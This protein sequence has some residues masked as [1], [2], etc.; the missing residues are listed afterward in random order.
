MSDYIFPDVVVRSREVDL[1]N[2]EDTLKLME[3]DSVQD[4]MNALAEH[5][6]A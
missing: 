4:I 3:M 5:G 2:R 6:A 1:L